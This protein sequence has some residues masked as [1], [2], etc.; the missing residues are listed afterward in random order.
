MTL[1][2]MQEVISWKGYTR[3]IYQVV[4]LFIMVVQE[5]KEHERSILAVRGHAFT[6]VVNVAVQL[7]DEDVYILAT[8]VF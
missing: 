3:V 6:H 7:G 8:V 5:A 1:Q 4:L 2:P